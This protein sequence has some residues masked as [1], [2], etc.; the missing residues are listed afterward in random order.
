MN[1]PASIET[2]SAA[3]RPPVYD[4]LSL[5][6]VRNALRKMHLI[7]RFEESAEDAY[8]RGQSYGTMH[9]SIG[10]EGT[11]VGIC[12]PL[13]DSDYITSTHRGHGHCIFEGA[14]VKRMFAEFLGRETGYCHGRGGS[15]HIADP[16]K[17]NLG[18]NGIVG[19]G[20]SDRRRRGA[21]R[22]EAAHR[23]GR[24]FILRRRSQ[25]R[26]RLP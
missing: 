17:G 20:A 15:M 23:R 18:A 26:G 25:Q 11:A 22:K 12:A 9:L 19:G 10:Q 3:N 5:A 14:E 7:R 24:G 6:Q 8:I 21:E 16:S 1:S 13:S 4:R 2:P